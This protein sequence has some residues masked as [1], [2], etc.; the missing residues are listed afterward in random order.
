MFLCVVTPTRKRWRWLRDQARALAPQLVDGD[1]WVVVIDADQPDPE[2]MDEIEAVAGSRL[3]VVN[4]VYRWT[5]P[6]MGNVN[7]ARNAGVAMAPIHCDGIVELDDHDIIKPG[8]IEAIREA[9]V[10]NADYVYGDSDQQAITEPMPGQFLLEVWPTVTRNEYTSGAFDR[11]EVDGVGIRAISRELWHALGG[12]HPR[13]FPGGDA[14]FAARAEKIGAKFVHL[15]KVLCT[16]TIDP[17]SIMG[18][19]RDI[20]KAAGHVAE[21]D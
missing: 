19:V 2:L 16:I 7:R 3:I 20:A 6:P 9:L 17:D 18:A 5:Y 15:D 14:D 13:A 8:A 21:G 4:L 10:Q 12:W 11:G 1:F